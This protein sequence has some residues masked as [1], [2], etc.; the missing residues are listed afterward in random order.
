MMKC[1]FEMIHLSNYLIIH[2][3]FRLNTIFIANKD[4]LNF[5]IKLNISS[6]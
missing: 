2:Y 6:T 3:L 4:T 5:R 1:H